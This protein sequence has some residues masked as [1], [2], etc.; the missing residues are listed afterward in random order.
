MVDSVEEPKRHPS[1]EAPLG[2]PVTGMPGGP[3]PVESQEQGL[4]RLRVLYRHRKLIIGTLLLGLA[5][6]VI[7]TYSTPTVYRATTVV[8]ADPDSTALASA[9][10]ATVAGRDL[11]RR[12]VRTLQ[13]AQNPQ[14]ET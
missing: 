13:L 11:Q 12:V 8:R 10:G 9:G 2:A 14:L 4:D 3:G 6:G 7:Q 1:H 5:A